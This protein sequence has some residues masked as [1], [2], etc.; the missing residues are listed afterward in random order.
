V[1]GT[2]VIVSSGNK[3]LPIPLAAIKSANL[4]YDVR[5]DLARAKQR[6]KNR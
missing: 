3:H 4:A 2:N 5:A 6:E 1:R